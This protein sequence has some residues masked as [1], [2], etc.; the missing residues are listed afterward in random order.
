MTG[1]ETEKKLEVA[2]E[3]LAVLGNG[4]LGYIREIEPDHAAKLLGPQINVPGDIR[5]YCLYGADGTP[6]SISAS[7]EAAFAAAR[8]HELTPVTVH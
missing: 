5:L 3:E 7:V 2:T 6:M 4:A 8:E 1:P